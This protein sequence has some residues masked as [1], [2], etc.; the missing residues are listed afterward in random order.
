MHRARRSP[1]CP[2]VSTSERTVP[3]QHWVGLVAIGAALVSAV[4]L[5]GLDGGRVAL[6]REQL[7][8]RVIVAC[9]ADDRQ[10]YLMHKACAEAENQA[11]DSGLSLAELP[12]LYPEQINPGGFV[13]E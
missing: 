11:E 13:P 2:A 9:E 3:S 1:T 10:S 12:A 8:R 4:V 7:L 5:L 6:E